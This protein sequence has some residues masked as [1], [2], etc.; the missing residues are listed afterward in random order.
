MLL[1]AMLNAEKTDATTGI[2][3]NFNIKRYGRQPLAAGRKI[4]SSS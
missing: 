2:Y 4:I 3:V 1:K